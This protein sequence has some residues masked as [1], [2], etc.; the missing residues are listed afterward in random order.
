[1]KERT[2][3]LIICSVLFVI[4]LSLNY[5][6]FFYSSFNFYKSELTI[7]GANITEKVYFSPN[8]DYHTLYRNFY[9]PLVIDPGHHSNYIQVNDIKCFSGKPYVYSRS[10]GCFSFENGINEADCMKFT[11]ENEYGCG[12]GSVLGF[13]ESVNYWIRAEYR[14][15]PSSIFSVNGKNYIKFVAYSP[16]K[17]VFLKTQDSLKIIGEAVYSK[18]YFTKE[19]VVIYIPYNGDLKGKSV[20]YLKNFE[21]DTNYWKYFIFFLLSLSPSIGLYIIW[22][23]FGKEANEIDVLDYLSDYPKERNGWEVAAFFVEPFGQLTNNLISSIILSLYQKKVIDIKTEK[24]FLV[25]NCYFKIIKESKNL[26]WMETEFLSILKFAIDNADK[27]YFKEGYLNFSKA[28]SSFKLKFSLPLKF[29]ALQKKLS[30]ESAQYTNSIGN[31]VYFLLHII[32]VPLSV[33][34]TR[35]V[36]IPIFLLASMMV[37]GIYSMMTNLLSR[38]NK[39]E[40][41]KEYK[42]WKGFKNYLSKAP[43]LRTQGH[44]AVI[45]W[46]KYMIY[47]TA[48]GIS[49]K[50]LDELKAKGII[51]EEQYHVYTS[52]HTFSGAVSSSG[53]TSGSGGH[54]GSGG[55]GVGGGGGG[56]R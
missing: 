27:K 31:I 33:L 29:A 46:N 5:L 20:I 12:F 52:V 54:S 49:K 32:L 39:E 18:Y 9:D 6:Y 43:S 37:I 55:G 16:Q 42:Q 24:A 47:A 41:Y 7:N 40:D 26:D 2:K 34:L 50:V 28:S 30:K 3:I 17:H 48:L 45:L 10:E 35:S 25:D 23:K 56:G 51:T 11:E 1:M 38:F 22:S 36:I 44:K 15:N 53:H 13:K 21:F 8:Q 4:A 19:N 14:L